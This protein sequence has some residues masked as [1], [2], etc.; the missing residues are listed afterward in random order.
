MRYCIVG[1][2]MKTELLSYQAVIPPTNLICPALDAYVKTKVVELSSSSHSQW[3][4]VVS[5]GIDPCPSLLCW[6]PGERIKDGKLTRRTKSKVSTSSLL[7]PNPK[8][9]IV[10]PHIAELQSTH[11]LSPLAEN[12]PTEH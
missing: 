11:P 9:P 3:G 12:E 7:S 2:K 5:G 6:N 4:D 8:G 10:D 1:Q